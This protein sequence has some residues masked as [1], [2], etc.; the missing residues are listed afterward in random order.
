[1]ATTVRIATADDAAQIAS[2]ID[3]ALSGPDPVGFDDPLDADAVGRWLDRQGHHGAMFVIEEDGELLG[4]AAVDF[5]SGSESECSLGAWVRTEHRRRGHAT[6][7][8]EAAL[9]FARERGYRRIRGRLPERNEPALSFLS[10][11]GGL[12]P[13]TNPGASFELPLASNEGGTR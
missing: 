7:L 1:M 10:S 11:I 3:D 2:I 4:F 8:A 5:D 13:L 12:V 9:A 6:T